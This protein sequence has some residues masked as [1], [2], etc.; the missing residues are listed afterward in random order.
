MSQEDAIRLFTDRHR[1]K[2]GEFVT[3][4]KSFIILHR[5]LNNDSTSDLISQKL[6][7]DEK[8]FGY[9]SVIETCSDDL[10]MM[11]ELY[12]INLSS[13][14][15]KYVKS[16]AITNVKMKIVRQTTEKADK[17]CRNMNTSLIM[18]NFEGVNFLIAQIISVLSALGIEG[19]L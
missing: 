16:L 12:K 2:L 9:F 6:F 17:T 18:E 5:C 14:Y 8:N 11:Q 15:S 10:K 19:E 1:H 13:L 3:N 4:T 7:E